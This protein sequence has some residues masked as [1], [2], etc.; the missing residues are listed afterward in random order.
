MPIGRSWTLRGLAT[1]TLLTG[2]CLACASA[3]ADGLDDLRARA[4]EMRREHGMKETADW[5]AEEAHRDGRPEQERAQLLSMAS[6]HYAEAGWEGR[7]LEL[8][9]A[10][11][12]LTPDDAEAREL[13]EKMEQLAERER[14]RARRDD[15]HER[16][17]DAR[18]TDRRDHHDRRP[19][20]AGDDGPRHDRRQDGRHDGPR[21]DDVHA[22]L[23]RVERQLREVMEHLRRTND[24]RDGPRGRVERERE[25]VEHHVRE[26]EREQEELQHELRDR[27][28]EQHEL[29]RELEHRER[30]LDRRNEALER[31]ERRVHE[32]E[33]ELERRERAM[34]KL[35]ERM[36]R[37]REELRQRIQE[38]EEGR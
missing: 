6:R 17:T 38:L 30:E 21:P 24:R 22:R 29:E 10:S 9:R 18:V 3:H 35:E 36:H 1:L 27:E 7:A 37:E 4:A 15:R 25:E 28:R 20:R 32:L 23:E 8:A 14:S 5:L 12:R 13:V 34:H 33:Q 2:L 11:L 31:M 19:D 16:E 26:L